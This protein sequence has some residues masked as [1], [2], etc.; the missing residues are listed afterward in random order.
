MG[1]DIGQCT[2]TPA[3]NNIGPMYEVCQVTLYFN[4]G[5]DQLAIMGAVTTESM[6][7]TVSVV[8]GTGEYLGAYGSCTF[9]PYENLDVHYVCD[10]FT[11][12]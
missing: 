1:Y 12:N 10:F 6:P 9:Q 3:I 11:P 8:G 2:N 7:Q 4:N 5:E